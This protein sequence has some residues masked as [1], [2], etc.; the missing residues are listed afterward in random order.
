MWIAGNFHVPSTCLQ[1]LNL[2]CGNDLFNNL[3]SF[4]SP[5]S[6]IVTVERYMDVQESR[7]ESMLGNA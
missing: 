3:V 7:L 6:I 2:S 4:D 5:V 1:G